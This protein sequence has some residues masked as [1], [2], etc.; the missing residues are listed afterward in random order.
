MTVL[1]EYC[2]AVVGKSAQQ[3]HQFGFEEVPQTIINPL[4]LIGSS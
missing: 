4:D 3:L 1:A 2:I